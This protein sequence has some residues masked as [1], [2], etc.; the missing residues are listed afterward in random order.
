[1]ADAAELRRAYEE[2]T[3]GAGEKLVRKYEARGD[4][5]ARASSDAAQQSYETAMKDPKVLKRRQTSLK[6]VSDQ[7]MNEAMRA[8]GAS[9]YAAATAAKAQKQAERALPYVNEAERLAANLPPKVRD[10]VQNWVQRGGPIAKRL[11]E[12]KEAG[13]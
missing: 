8:T 4:K 13:R 6:R 1:M 12:M 2:G 10:P 7:E 3:S 5:A 11:R 9:A